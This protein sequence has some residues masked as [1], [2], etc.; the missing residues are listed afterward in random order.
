ML[1]IED[2]SSLDEVETKGN[3]F[4]YDPIHQKMMSFDNRSFS[5]IQLFNL[6]GSLVSFSKESNVLD[7]SDV[8][9]GL[10]LIV[11]DNGIQQ[12]FVKF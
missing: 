9:L 12:K 1:T 8:S 5:E 7:V 11:C 3:L 10:Y 2:V 4:F 6:N